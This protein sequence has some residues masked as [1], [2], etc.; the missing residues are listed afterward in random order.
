MEVNDIL[1]DRDTLE[2]A[3]ADGDMVVGESTAQHQTLIM[4]AARG[5]FKESPTL[6]VGLMN[7]LYDETPGAL[8]ADIRSSLRQDGMTVGAVELDGDATGDDFGIKID[9]YYE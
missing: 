4:L 3:Y 1:L 5:D 6:G 7:Y 9:A 8:L 2:M